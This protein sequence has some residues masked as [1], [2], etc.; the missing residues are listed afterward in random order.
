MARERGSA[1][2][3]VAKTL[4][5]QKEFSVNQRSLRDR[6]STLAR[7]VKA[8]LAKEERA[9]GGGEVLQSESDKLVEELITLRDESEKKGEDQSEAKREAVVNEKK[10][11]LE[12]RDR[13]LEKI[14]E[15][16]KRN[17]EE[18]AEEKK[19]VGIKRRRSG[20]DMLEWLRERAESDLEIKKQ[21]IKEKRE[22]REAMEATR[23]EQQQQQ[24]QQQILQVLRQQQH[25]QQQQQQQQQQFALMQQQ[26]MGM[27]QQQQQQMQ[28]LLSFL[29]KKE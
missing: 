15:T 9:S 21:E 1:W 2:D 24:Q 8:K 5:C 19:T 4:N 28:A 13:A 26:M 10:Q 27:F 23:L 7:K 22:E 25:Y 3:V 17:E 11:A 29:Q 14:G 16:R 20:G 6:F 18:R 12:M